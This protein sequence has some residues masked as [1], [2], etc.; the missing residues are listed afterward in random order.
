ME[1][2]N[3]ANREVRNSVFLD[4]FQRKKY[5]LQLYR[6][7]HPEDSTVTE[8]DLNVITLSNILVRDI[9]NDL[10]F[11]VGNRLIILMEAQTQWSEN[12]VLRQLFY[13][14]QTL[15]NWIE[16]H[17][18][19]MYGTRRIT[20]PKMEAYVI[21]TGAR[22]DLPEQLSLRDLYG[23]QTDLDIRVRILRYEEGEQDIISQYIRFCRILTLQVRKYRV[24]LKAIE[25]T[26]A[27]CENENV[28]REYLKEHEREVRDMIW[29]EPVFDEEIMNRALRN[30]PDP[31]E[32]LIEEERAIYR[33][34]GR[35]DGRAEGR[36]E[37]LAEGREE[38]LAEGR[39]EGRA[40]G[41]KEGIAEG[42]TEGIAQ[43]NRELVLRQA[44]KGLSY[45]E[46]ADLNDLPVETVQEIAESGTINP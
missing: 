17:D 21:Y 32:D 39:E 9:Y 2:T 13:I 38:G 7:L 34:M 14:V 41:H 20:L 31:I 3:K 11:S 10:G 33:M 28:L 26:I 12:I 15:R 24:S 30:N 35:E 19:S 40:E 37:G 5:L 4:L 25:S 44:A 23:E 1:T 27:I 42:I 16:D 46:I 36:A 43:R 29:T 45:E 6:T 18:I 22:M 8:E